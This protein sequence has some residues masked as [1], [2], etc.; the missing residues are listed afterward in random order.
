MAKNDWSPLIQRWRRVYKST[1]L[2]KK[3]FSKSPHSI[4]HCSYYDYE[5]GANYECEAE[6]CYNYED[7]VGEDEEEDVLQCTTVAVDDGSVDLGG[8]GGYGTAAPDLLENFCDLMVRI[9]FFFFKMINCLSF[10]KFRSV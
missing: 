9:T 6:K 2:T 3:T 7:N 10:S 5:Y 8:G 4:Y 1:T